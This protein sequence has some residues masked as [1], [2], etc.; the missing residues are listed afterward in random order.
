MTTSSL[1]G[2]PTGPPPVH[3]S[4]RPPVDTSYRCHV[5]GSPMH[6]AA[7]IGGFDRHPTCDR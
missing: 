3:P 2:G 7:T 5:C 4:T 6:W 1:T